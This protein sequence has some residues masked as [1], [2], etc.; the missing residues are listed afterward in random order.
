MT[1]CNAFNVSNLGVTGEGNANRK[2]SLHASREGLA[3]SLS[4]VFKVQDA[5]DPIHLVRDFLFGV[6]L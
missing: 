1:L 6:A 4:L 3:P 2:L 5:N